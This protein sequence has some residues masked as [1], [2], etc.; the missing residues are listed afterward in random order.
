[1]LSPKEKRKASQIYHLL[2]KIKKNLIKNRISVKNL[3][4]NILKLGAN[5][6]D[7]IQ[8]LDINKLVQPYK[9]NKKYRIFVSYYL[10]STRL[11]DNV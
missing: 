4:K 8:I 3:R 10:G 9:K 7:Y 2:I 1:M 5:R 6:I 11:I